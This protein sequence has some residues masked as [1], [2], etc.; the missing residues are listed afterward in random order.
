MNNKKTISQFQHFP[1]HLVDPSPWPILLSFSLLNLTVGA[2]AYMHGF[3][4]GGYILT[5]G[6]LLTTYGMILFYKLLEYGIR[7]LSIR[8]GFQLRGA[9]IAVFRK[10]SYKGNRFIGISVIGIGVCVVSVCL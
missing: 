9:A 8:Y 6:L 3:S 5:L 7:N 4:Y 10:A 2:V 1:F